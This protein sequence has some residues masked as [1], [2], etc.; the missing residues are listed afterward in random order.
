MD[1]HYPNRLEQKL[2][3]RQAPT[4]GQGVSGDSA[5]VSLKTRYLKQ[6]SETCFIFQ[7]EQEIQNKTQKV[8]L[9]HVIISP[10]SLLLLQLDGD[11]SHWA[12]LNPLHKM[13]DIATKY[14]CPRTHTGSH[15]YPERLDVYVGVL[16]LFPQ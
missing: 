3:Y 7:D 9:R 10:L 14:K 15:W 11:T 4:A 16:V 13:C 5:E 1:L 6:F 2:T 12:S 8:Y